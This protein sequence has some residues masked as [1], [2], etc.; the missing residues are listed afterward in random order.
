MTPPEPPV[1]FAVVGLGAFGATSA[2]AVTSTPG[3]RLVAVADLDAERARETGARYGVDW[4]TDYREL[5][6]RAD[7]DV[8]GVF[9]PSNK[10]RDIVVEAA[11]AGKH[12]LVTKPL[13]ISLDRADAMITAC[14]EAGVE[15]FCEFYLRY[16]AENF[17]IHQAIEAGALG[18][19]VL[20]DFS[21]KCYRPQSYYDA[22]G[23]WRGKLADSG[24]GIVINQSIHAVDKLRWY[25]GEVESVQ[26]L[27]G[28]FTHDIEVE[29]TAAALLKM[30]S[31]AIGML[32]GTATFHNTNPVH[33]VY[34]GGSTS[35]SEVNGD[36]GSVIAIDN[37]ITMWKTT[38][39]FDPE[40]GDAGDGPPANVF[41]DVARTL[42]DPGYS[43]S[44]LVRGRDARASLEVVLALYESAR[45]GQL[46]R[47]SGVDAEV[48]AR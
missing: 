18:K 42:R 21:Y 13:E 15:L 11:R 3:T 30:R 29:D 14:E 1:N 46:V 2:E 44:T 48:E 47:V 43:S 23:G 39:D 32:V 24:G 17:R 8:I 5:L 4:T 12:V 41:A 35:R 16:M 45:T 25:L 40:P 9:T 36:L 7:I 33:P 31:G 10:H 27:T 28:T 34:G 22:D 26:A 6:T 20:G 19:V 37:A 38:G